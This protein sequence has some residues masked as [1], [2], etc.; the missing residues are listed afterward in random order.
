MVAAR[1]PE[2]SQALLARETQCRPGQV[3]DS[4][5]GMVVLP[6]HNRLAEGCFLL[7]TACGTRFLYQP[8]QGITI[9]RAAAGKIG[10]EELWLH[11][12]VYAAVACLNGFLPLHA[13]AVANDGQVTAITGPAGA[14]KSTLAAGLGRLGLPLFCDDTLLLDLANLDRL[15]CMPGHK[16]LKLL[17]DALALTGA[18]AIQTVGADTGKHYARPTAGIVAE[19]LPLKRLIFLAEA[20]NL[21]WTAISGAQRF[22][23]LEDDHHT[24]DL[25]LAAAQPSRSELFSLRAAIASGV[26][27]AQL[28]RPRSSEGFAA[29]VSLVAQQIGAQEQ[30]E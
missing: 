27:M 8:G 22:A 15:I 3:S 2:Q 20:E 18:E 10:E 5:G 21:G 19:P 11:G 17:P 6:G 13:S 14:G 24:Q 4:L 25:F 9:D 1:T 7:H 23:R 29:S 26:E 16:R 30:T 28:A 12:S